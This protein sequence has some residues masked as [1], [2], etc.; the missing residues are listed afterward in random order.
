MP[1]LIMKL[2]VGQNPQDAGYLARNSVCPTHPLLDMVGQERKPVKRILAKI[3]VDKRIS[4]V[5]RHQSWQGLTLESAANEFLK[6][7]LSGGYSQAL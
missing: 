7:A 3:A 1:G 6:T 4:F 2:L 5:A